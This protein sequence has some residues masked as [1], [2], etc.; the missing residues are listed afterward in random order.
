M[1][2]M[3]VMLIGGLVVLGV[4][5][6]PPL[7]LAL[8]GFWLSFWTGEVISRGEQHEY[9]LLGITTLGPILLGTL[10]ATRVHFTHQQLAS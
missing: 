5:L 4:R 6:P 8:P 3:R 10:A 7:A 1:T 9:L 2:I